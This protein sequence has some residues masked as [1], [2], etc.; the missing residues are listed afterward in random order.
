[1]Q[2]QL[3]FSVA[4]SEIKK[5]RACIPRTRGASSVW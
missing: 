4:S 2:L 3:P 1:M 5:R